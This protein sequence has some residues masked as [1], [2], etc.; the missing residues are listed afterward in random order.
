MRRAVVLALALLCGLGCGNATDETREPP[1]KYTLE[2]DGKAHV[3]E[4]GEEVQLKGTFTDPKV[5]LTPAETRLFTYGGVEFQYP[6]Y[7]AWE[8]DAEE[9][10]Y[11]NWT[12][13]GNDFKIL[14]FDAAGATSADE[15]AAGIVKRFGEANCRLTDV[16]LVLG[17]TKHDGK[18]IATRLAGSSFVQTV[19]RLPAKGRTKMLVLQDSPPDEKQSTKETD[20]ALKLLRTTFK[21]R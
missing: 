19:V 5:K 13:S 15:Y 14:L 8:A 4:A 11:K 7:F 3:V 17:G 10:D 9:D 18:R 16:T 1:L 21:V 12:L 6:A 20:L 2:V